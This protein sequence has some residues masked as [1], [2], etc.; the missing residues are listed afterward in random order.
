ML[1]HMRAAISRNQQLAVWELEEGLGI[2]RTIISEILTE[3]V[4][5]SRVSAKFVPQVLSQEQKEFCAGA[6]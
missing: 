1:E 6:A 2:P 3:D 4:G 5:M